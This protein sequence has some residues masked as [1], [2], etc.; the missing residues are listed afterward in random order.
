[1]YTRSVSLGRRGAAADLHA[2]A[3]IREGARGAATLARAP[4]DA[5]VVGYGVLAEGRDG[6]YVGAEHEEATKR[7][8]RGKPCRLQITTRK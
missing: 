6:V 4:V 5:F 7:A 2:G 3:P 1:V 8:A